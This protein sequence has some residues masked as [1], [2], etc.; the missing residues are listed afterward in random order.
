MKKR[1]LPWLS[2]LLPLQLISQNDSS[3]VMQPVEIS[4]KR[5]QHLPFDQSTRNVQVITQS[6]LKSMPVQSVSE[7]LSYVA[8][9][10]LRQRGPYGSQGDLS[11]LGGTFE[12]VLVLID[13]IPMRDPQ[14]GH[15]QLNLPIDLSQ[16]ERIEILK[17][18]ACRIYGANSLAGAI[19]I[20]TK[21]PGKEKVFLQAFGASPIAENDVKST[22]FGMAGGRISIGGESQN[23]RS[24]HQLDV[25]FLRTDGYRY[26]SDNTQQ[27]LGYRGNYQLAGGVLK[28]Q[29]G[30]AINQFGANGFYAYPFDTDAHEKVETTYGGIHFEKTISNWTLRPLAYVRYNHDDYIFVKQS[31]EVY[32]NNHFTTSAGLELHASHENRLG[33]IGLGY[34][35]RGEIIHSNNLGHRERYYHSF[36]FEQHF[37]WSSGARLV[38]GIQPQ[39]S[40]QFGL[41]VYPGIEWSIPINS[42]LRTYGSVSLGSRNPTFTDMFYSDRANIGNPSLNPEQSLSAELGLRRNAQS[43]EF[44]AAAFVRRTGDFIDYTRANDGEKWKPENFLLLTT[45]G[46]N[47]NASYRFKTNQQFNL[48]F[49]RI[50]Y[51]LLDVQMAE[52]KGQSKYAISHLRHQFN[53]QA[54]INTTKWI[55]HSFSFRYNERLN[56]QQYAVADY[57][58]RAGYKKWAFTLDVNNFLDRQY[59]ESGFIPMPGRWYRVGVEWRL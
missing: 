2:L 52:E 4:E 9:V 24:G 35:S 29:A 1:A 36:Y 57:R 49:V 40:A 13:G 31:P 15:N 38:A 19:N 20:V 25:S 58:L 41:K 22:P 30:T 11:M 33:Q 26:N 23:K 45:S 8:G 44:N 34:E 53:A 47:T 17:G 16:I 27:R 5:I 6:D 7:V 37:T 3:Y 39:Y 56:A 54:V 43:M 48:A 12:Q 59:I 10:D 46:L 51:T 14:T 50:G 21:T 28:L 32:R 18:T 55:Q 42:S